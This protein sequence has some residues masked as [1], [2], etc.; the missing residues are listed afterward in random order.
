[1]EPGAGHD[2]PAVGA[3]E[4]VRTARAAASAADVEVID[5]DD[6]DTMQA[7]ARLLDEVRWPAHASTAPSPQQLLAMALAGEQVSVARHGG[8]VLGGT[9]ARRDAPG[10]LYSQVTVVRDADAGRGVGRA[11]KWHQRAWC[12]ERG[13]DRVRWHADP[14]RR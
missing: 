10:G 14:L 1:M 7:V 12:L 6:L 13:I 9:V 4:P 5:V 2:D 3:N 8:S 11:L